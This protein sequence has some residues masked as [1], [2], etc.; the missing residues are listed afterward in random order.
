MQAVTLHSIK[1]GL[2]VENLSVA[3]LAYVLP[4][5]K[6]LI[7]TALYLTFCGKGMQNLV[8]SWEKTL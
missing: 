7:R 1:A 2:T 8:T 3:I 6:V 5:F 4:E